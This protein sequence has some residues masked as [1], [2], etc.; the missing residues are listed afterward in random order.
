MRSLKGKLM[1]FI[2]TAVM[3][4]GGLGMYSMPAQAAEVPTISIT[5][6][7]TQSAKDQ[8]F[9]VYV[10]AA[11][12]YEAYVGGEV[13]WSGFLG[14]GDNYLSFPTSDTVTLMVYVQYESGDDGVL[15]WYLQ[16]ANSAN[17]YYVTVSCVGDDGTFLQSETIELSKYNNPEVAYYGPSSFDYGDVVYTPVNNG[18]LL[19]YGSGNATITYTASTKEAHDFTV[20]YVDEQDRVLSTYSKKLN[21]GEAYQIDAPAT[22]SAGGRNYQ[23][24][25]ANASVTVTY[26][27]AASVYTFEYAEVIEA[28]AEPY[29]I[30]I[31]LV[32]ADN[33]NAVLYTIRQTVDVNGSVHVELPLTYEIN[34]K[35]YQLAEGVQN[36]IE[37]EFASTRSTVYTIPYTVAEESAPY[38][39]TVNFVD[40]NNP[41][42][43]L[44]ATTATVT[45]DGDPFIY[46]VNSRPTMEIGGTQY[47]IIAGQGN[48][49]G[50]IVHTYGMTN[51][52]YNVY[53]S[54]EK[55]DEPDAYTVTVRYISIED[56]AV[57]DTQQQNVAY[58]A[59]VNFGEAPAEINVG[60]TNYVRLNGQD[61]EI[62]HEYNEG[63]TS[64]AVYYRDS[65]VEVEEEPEVITQVITQ[66]V[67]QD[68]GTVAPNA[69]GTVVP[70]TVPV[71]TVNGG[72]Q[73]NNYNADG[74]QVNVEDGQIVNLED[75]ETPLGDGESIGQSESQD[76]T[77]ES[78]TEAPTET[79]MD[80]S[81]PLGNME[82]NNDSGINMGLMAGII[83][84]ILMIAGAVTFIVIKRRNSVNS[85]K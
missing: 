29:E 45:P 40:Y 46:D 83:V 4:L 56:N 69:D 30:T 32:D 36:F 33:D 42:V 34:F 9:S 81:I 12:E 59:S 79:L 38:I 64:Y 51:R 67:T 26:D 70:V 73:Q 3:V 57:L 75:E 48:D 22:L 25:T 39:V 8:A 21:Y 53:Y 14:A 50:Q 31:N 17:A 28:P 1:S 10:S 37:R 68:D 84:L 24:E 41:S 18:I 60:D 71:T 27:N 19:Q 23:L 61:G 44:S 76:E 6:Q 65:S 47:Q 85:Q 20:N 63:Q 49:S 15:D 78:V 74:Q 16:Q 55:V 7:R 66:Y 43:V 72:G 62:I 5:P 13:A 35:Q 54:A 82:G 52:I 11:G 2:L 58:G 77:Q 80:E